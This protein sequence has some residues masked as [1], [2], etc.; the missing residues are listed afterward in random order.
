MNLYP[1]TKEPMTDEP[2]DWKREIREAR[3]GY[4]KVDA[5]A[6]HVTPHAYL[7]DTGRLLE[8][9][10]RLEREAEEARRDAAALRRAFEWSMEHQ[11]CSAR[12]MLYLLIGAPARSGSTP[13]DAGDFGRCVA[14]LDAVWP[15]GWPD[16]APVAEKGGPVW[17][18]IVAAWPDLL[19]KWTAG[20][21]PTYERFRAMEVRSR[22]EAR[23]AGGAP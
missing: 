2:T 18:G 6:A 13:R 20:D 3:D 22:E 23:A 19:R 8:E 7:R 14:M 17:A 21:G 16:L 5:Y 10:D 15:H 9:V 11:G 4:A 12:S 1:C